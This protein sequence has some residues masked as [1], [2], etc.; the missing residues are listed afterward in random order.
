MLEWL[1]LLPRP[2]PPTTSRDREADA[3]AA[4]LKRASFRAERAAMQALAADGR[5]ETA[6]SQVQRMLGDLMAEATR[7]R[8]VFNRDRL[9]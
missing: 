8:S 5:L 4:D 9:P 3:A 7:D 1:H 2:Q 6:N